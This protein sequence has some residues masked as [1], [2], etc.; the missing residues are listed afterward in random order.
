MSRSLRLL[1]LPLL[2]AVVM[3][4]SLSS[5]AQAD[6]DQDFQLYNRTEVDIHHLYVS[7][8]ESDDW[9]E[10]LLGG[11]VLQNGADVEV[12]FHPKTTAAKWDIRVE[13]KQGNALYWRGINLLQVEEIILEPDGKARL[14]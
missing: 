6:G 5:V 7:P 3:A 8:T 1:I 10:D 9:E 13:D 2:L 4:L 12:S 11:H 14:K